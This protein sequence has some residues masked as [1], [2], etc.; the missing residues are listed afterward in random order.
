MNT[1]LHCRFNRF[2]RPLNVTPSGAGQAADGGAVCR[3]HL[4]SNFLHR[5]K[6]TRAGKGKPGFNDIDPQSSQLSRNHQLL[7]HIQ[8]GPRRL[9]PVPQGGVKDQNALWAG[10]VA[11]G[12]SHGV[13][14]KGR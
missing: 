2:A 8:G 9:F 1:P 10:R 11:H 14:S 3:A 7:F 4:A 13:E 12:D 6:I 5:L